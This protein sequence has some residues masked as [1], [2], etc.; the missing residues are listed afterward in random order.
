MRLK[1][2]DYKGLEIEVDVHENGKFRCAVDGIHVESDQGRGFAAMDVAV[3]KAQE[4]IDA[5]LA[6]NPKTYE[7]L[8]AAL[9]ESLVWTYEECHLD[10]QLVSLLVESFI[11]ARK[12]Q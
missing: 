9:Q 10:P 4:A 6:T 2:I 8:T 5:F 12:G 3:T 7:E 1:T 11:T